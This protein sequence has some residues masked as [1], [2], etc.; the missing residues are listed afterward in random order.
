MTVLVR[1]A[2]PNDLVALLDLYRDLHER[3]E[4]AGPDACGA[5]WSA[6]LADPKAR[7]LLLEAKGQVVSSCVLFVHPN[8]SRGARPFGLI[9]NVVTRSGCRQRGYAGRLLDHALA[10]AWAEGCYKVMLLTGRT[11]PSVHRLYTRA[12]FRSGIKVGYMAYPPGGPP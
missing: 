10:L 8:L 2:A 6:L 3:D 12:G 4:P 5:A 9:E 7:V 11:D 1:E